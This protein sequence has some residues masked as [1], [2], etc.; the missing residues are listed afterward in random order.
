M[1]KAEKRP[2]EC[3]LARR[4]EL[5]RW[6]VLC[7]SQELQGHYKNTKW[8]EKAIQGICDMSGSSPYIVQCGGDSLWGY[9]A[10]WA[11]GNDKKVR[12][13]MDDVTNV[14]QERHGKVDWDKMEEKR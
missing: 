3:S 7:E 12:D 2:G 8:I 11:K 10:Q 6:L 9:W 4:T 13:S 5:N 14:V 1:P